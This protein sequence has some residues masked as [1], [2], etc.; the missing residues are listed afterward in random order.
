MYAFQAALAQKVTGQ[1]PVL[2]IS[3]WTPCTH[4]LHWAHLQRVQNALA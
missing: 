2:K 4:T 3:A 1:R